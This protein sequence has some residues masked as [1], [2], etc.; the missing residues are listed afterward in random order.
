MKADFIAPMRCVTTSE[1]LSGPE[2]CY[3]LKLDGYRDTQRS[4]YCAKTRRPHSLYAKVHK[5][6]ASKNE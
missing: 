1:V 2:G 5:R 6:K 3:E 4:S